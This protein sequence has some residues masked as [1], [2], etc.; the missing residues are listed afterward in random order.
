MSNR[1]E[2]NKSLPSFLTALVGALIGGLLVFLLTNGFGAK[3]MKAP[4]LS[5]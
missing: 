1:Q 3:G 2:G 4:L 5:Q